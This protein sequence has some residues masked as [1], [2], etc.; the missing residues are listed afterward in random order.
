ML[1]KKKK[2]ALNPGPPA[3]DASTLPLGYRGG[4][5]YYWQVEMG[6]DIPW[7]LKASK[8]TEPTHGRQSAQTTSVNHRVFYLHVYNCSHLQVAF[9]CENVF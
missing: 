8:L 5:S 6:L 7:V 9:P 3:L 1:K 2:R 4:G